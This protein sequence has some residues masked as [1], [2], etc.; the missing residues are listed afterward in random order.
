MP[1]KRSLRI[2]I[3]T[4]LWISFLIS[5]SFQKLDF[6]ISTNSPKIYFSTELLEELRDSILKPKLS[7]HFGIDS[8]E[9]M[10]EALSDYIEIVTIKSEVNICRDHKDN[11]VLALCKNA[12]ADYLLTG[13]NDLLELK[14][15]GKTQIKTIADFISETK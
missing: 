9:E 4:N 14:K 10:L 11:F 6:I 2:V 12:K 3:D 8:I 1:G 15:F 7:K 13:D 5:K